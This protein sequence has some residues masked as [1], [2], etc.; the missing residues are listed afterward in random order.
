M[1][2]RPR[3][4]EV[5]AH[6]RARWV[7]AA[8][9]HSDPHDDPCA[10]TGWGGA[11]VRARSLGGRIPRHLEPGHFDKEVLMNYGTTNPL[12]P[13]RIPAAQQPRARRQAVPVQ[14]VRVHRRRG[15][16]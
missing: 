1:R 16:S 14:R 3:Y 6:S 10:P 15:R 9:R 7:V 8:F 2:L 5:G 12:R 13:I 4:G 11:P